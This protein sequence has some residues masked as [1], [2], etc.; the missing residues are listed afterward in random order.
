[1][2]LSDHLFI[3]LLLFCTA[4]PVDSTGS[5][6]WSRK[7]LRPTSPPAD[8]VRQDDTGAASLP[9]LR[10]GSAERASHAASMD[11]TVKRPTR[12]GCYMR[13]PSG[14]PKRPMD[15]Q[16]WRHD[17]WAEKDGLDEARCMERA[18]VWNGFCGSQDAMMAF[19]LQ[20]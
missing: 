8:D 4:P 17:P 10:A 14:C 7:A 13:M 18:A 19:V 2:R 20:Q 5:W 1:M 16:L 15:T 12:V 11:G 6:P 9:S 3:S